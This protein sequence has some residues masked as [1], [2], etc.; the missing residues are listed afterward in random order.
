MSDYVVP[1]Q[2]IQEYMRELREGVIL[3]LAAA[4]DLQALYRAQGK[5]GLLDTLLGLRDIMAVLESQKKED[6]KRGESNS[7]SHRSRRTDRAGSP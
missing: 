3:D 5:L 4:D 7:D 2:N 6:V 1:W